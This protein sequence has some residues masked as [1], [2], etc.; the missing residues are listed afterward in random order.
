ME[1]ARYVCVNGEFRRS[2]DPFL[3]SR[4]RAFRFG[5]ALVENIHA[6]ATEAQFL[7]QHFNRLLK[8]MDLL[9]MKMPAW[10]TVSY[11]A[12]LISRLLN[13]N[14]IFGGAA[15]RLT[16][17]R[18]AGGHLKP[19]GNEVS[20]ILESRSMQENYYTLNEKGLVVDL[21]REYRVHSGV[22]SGI[23]D[24][25]SLVYV[26]AS[27]YCERNHLD[28]TL[29]LNETGRIAGTYHANI[30]LVKDGALFTPGLDQG[31]RAGVMRE[32]IIKISLDSGMRVN[33]EGSF[34]PA[35]LEDA[36]EM[37]LTNAL[38]GIR[39]VGAYQLKRYYRKT[40]QLLIRTLNKLAF[41]TP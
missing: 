32:V 30:F 7:E 11:V 40:S 16:L 18:E 1:D 37:F 26:L 4:N 19:E 41:G 21:C 23:K 38:E 22:L 28:E 39:W 14:R 24:T 12:Q 5:D 15:V 35:V 33:D 17:Y 31:C 10:L 20:F 8:G 34:T 27:L 36:D 9:Y 29:L 13:R 6:F 3:D 2:S 25:G